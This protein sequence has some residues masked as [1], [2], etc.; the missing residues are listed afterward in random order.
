MTAAVSPLAPKTVPDLP[1]VAGV[2]FATAEAGIK[3]KNR[4]DVLLATFV[5][6]TQ[7]AGVLTRSLC[8]SAPVAS[9][10]PSSTAA[11]R[12]RSTARALATSPQRPGQHSPPPRKAAK[13]APA[14]RVV[15]AARAQPPRV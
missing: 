6:G 7:V 9:A 15:H 11:R 5:A 1:A 3:Y 4:T 10:W 2:R 14:V 8:P 12:P 13:V